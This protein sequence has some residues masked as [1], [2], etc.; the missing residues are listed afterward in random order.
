MADA[1]DG[2]PDNPDR[3]GWHWLQSER[4]SVVAPKEWRA[5]ETRRWC[6]SNGELRADFQIADRYRYLGPCHTPAE[7]IAMVEAA[8][9][10]MRQEVIDYLSGVAERCETLRGSETYRERGAFVRGLIDP[11]VRTL[12]LPTPD[13]DAIREQARR[14]GMETAGKIADRSPWGTWSADAIRAA[15]GDGE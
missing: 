4:G 2:K 11:H 3:D 13:L 15:M 7:V 14:E 12:P 1:W 8:G 6:M 10:Q 5:G 9:E